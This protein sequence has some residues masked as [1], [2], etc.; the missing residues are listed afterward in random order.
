MLY[1]NL[2]VVLRGTTTL[3]VTDANLAEDDVV[4]GRVDVERIGSKVIGY[5]I[6]VA[7]NPQYRTAIDH[8]FTETYSLPVADESVE[9]PLD[10]WQ[11]DFSEKD[12]EEIQKVVTKHLV[13][14]ARGSIMRRLWQTEG[15]EPRMLA[16]NFLMLTAEAL[17]SDSSD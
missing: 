1:K 12:W 7:G 15:R 14:E 8:F 11:P 17:F 16:A 3:T 6:L 9:L 2:N 13:G 4:I 10:L 5:R